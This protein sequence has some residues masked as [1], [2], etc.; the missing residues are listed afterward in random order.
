MS[1]PKCSFLDQTSSS[2]SRSAGD[3]LSEDIYDYDSC[4]YFDDCGAEPDAQTVTPGLK[5]AK[6]ASLSGN[7]VSHFFVDFDTN[8]TNDTNSGTWCFPRQAIRTLLPHSYLI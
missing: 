1:F 4:Y 6:L 7:N 5:H 2:A 8:D 3:L